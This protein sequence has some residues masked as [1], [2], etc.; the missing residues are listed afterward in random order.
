MLIK[1]IIISIIGS[2][3]NIL[4]ISYTSHIYIF[5]NIINT[6]IFEN[7]HLINSIYL[8]LVISI[9]YVYLKDIINFFI[10]PIKKKLKNEKVNYKRIIKINT[11]FLITTILS[12]IIIYLIPK[13]TMNIKNIPIYL[14]I[15]SIFIIISSNKKG[16]KTIKEFTILDSLIFSIS[17]LLN[18]IPTI[19]PLCSNIFISKIIKLNKSTS[20]KYSLFTLIPFYIIKSIP[21][22]NYLISNIEYL[23]YYLLTIL[24]TTI[25]SI[26][27]LNYLKDIY[28][29]NKLY[30]LSIYTFI[31]GIFLIYWFR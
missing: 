17:H 19:S 5:N 9:T 29:N 20:L 31:L 3:T 27:T 21:T 7:N 23:P 24:I 8:S 16:T 25:I 14:F 15:L 30:K 6:K 10:F 12:T 1:Y 11:Y 22:I 13:L 2:I 26:K 28:Y 4:P 18:T